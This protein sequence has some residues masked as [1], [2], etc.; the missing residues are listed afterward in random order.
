M[1]DLTE[2]ALHEKPEAPEQA[3]NDLAWSC[4]SRAEGWKDLYD[5]K[6]RAIAKGSATPSLPAISLAHAEREAMHLTLKREP[7]LAADLIETA[8]TEHATNDK[9][10]GW[11]L[12]VAAKYRY[13]VDEGR[14]FQ[15]QAAAHGKNDRMLPPPTGTI[16]R[17]EKGDRA[18]AATAILRWYAGFNN[19]NGAIAAL[20]G[21]RGRLAF[22]VSADTME[23]ALMELAVF[24]GA[25]GSRPEHTLGRGPD[26][27]WL[28][29]DA[30]FVI[31][32]KNEAAYER[33]P[34]KDS[35]QLHDSLQ[36]FREVHPGREPNPIIVA[37]ATR[38]E[39]DAHFPDGTRVLTPQGLGKFVAN[40]EGLLRELVK[41]PAAQWTAKDVAQLLARW[42]LTSS[43][44]NGNYTEPVQ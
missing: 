10:K 8:L 33:L 28:F 11:Y 30:S 18:D 43:Q 21:V 24:V 32:A 20:Q 37:R 40:V 3:V 14:A 9:Q 2:I 26:D 35:C 38:A 15:T 27:L 41:R 1:H 36:W 16:L 23:Q 4:L 13:A 25:D 39:H 34:K 17:P 29:N 5:E 44:F 31:E 12:Q 22:D 42:K 7:N 19:V 6:V